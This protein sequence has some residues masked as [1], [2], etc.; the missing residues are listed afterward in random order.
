MPRVQKS[1]RNRPLIGLRIL[2]NME[3]R[4]DG[5]WEGIIYNADDGN[6]Y[7]SGDV[8]GDGLADFMVC[9]NGVPTIQGIDFGP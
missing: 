3:D 9:I 6:T 5:K 2:Q 1:L 7:V 8:N 4:G